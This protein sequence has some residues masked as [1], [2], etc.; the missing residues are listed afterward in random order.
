[1][2]NVLTTLP[3]KIAESFKKMTKGQKTRLFVLIAIIIAIII[4]V[5][6]V[7]NQ[8]NYVVVFSG[9]AAEA[10]EVMTA[11]DEMNVDYMP[12]GAGTILVEENAAPGV[13]MQLATQGYPSSGLSTEIFD[14]AS[15]LGMTDMEKNKYWQMQQQEKLRQDVLKMDKVEDA[16]VNLDLG[17]SSSFVLSNDNTEPT[18]S[19]MLILKNNQK[20]TESETKSIAELVSGAVSGMTTENV[21]IVDSKGNVYSTNANDITGT[22]DTQ[23]GIQDAVQQKLQTQII[24][25]LSAIVGE[26]NVRATVNV[27]LNF[28]SKSTESVEFAPPVNG[29]EGLAVSM[30]ELVEEITNNTTGAV[31]GIDANG[32]ASQYLNALNENADNSVYY[33]A[34][35]EA[36]YEL[37]QTKTQIEQAKGQIEELSVSVIINSDAVDD[38]SEEIKQLVATAV[39][40]DQ[41]RITVLPLPFAQIEDTA[42]QDSIDQQQGMLASMQRAETMRLAIILGTV[43]IV[44]F[45]LFMIFKM[46]T[47]KP[48]PVLAEGGFDYI[49]DEETMPGGREQQIESFDDI[50]LEDFEKTD[51]KLNILE[52]YI[53][54]NP[55]SV[56]NLLRNWLNED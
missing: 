38:Y 14:K 47:K 6:V 53:G 33:Q 24:N 25:L 52:D 35:R 46:F 56:A 1:M 21:R 42:V 13:K 50:K 26:Q 15:G 5:S 11:L 40:V 28:D 20:L 9:S 32:T 48:E 55:E 31:A 29:T 34:S 43:L 7:L 49:V 10:G 4:V 23:L 37:N 12:Q 22:V 44:M 27:K 3:A 41:E 36:N 8:K 45:F 16:S 30:K 54:K 39:G 17:E 18:A 19:V 51:N 2:A